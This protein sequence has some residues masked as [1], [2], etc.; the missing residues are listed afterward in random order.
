[1]VS[2]ILPWSKS[3]GRWAILPSWEVCTYFAI[4]KN[5]CERPTASLIWNMAY[6]FSIKHLF[7][8]FAY[9]HS[10]FWSLH[11]NPNN[12]SSSECILIEILCVLFTLTSSKKFKLVELF[13]QSREWSKNIWFCAT[14]ATVHAQRSSLAVARLTLT[15]WRSSLKL[16]FHLPKKLF[17]L[18]Q[19]K[20]FKNE[21]NYFLF[22][23]KS[24][25]SSQY[26]LVM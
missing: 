22:H 14:T 13:F 3:H 8:L 1:M 21:E 15:K 7:L 9:F 5:I 11:Q 23:L 26:F 20:P 24:Y 19:W 4:L 25:F 17:Y 18:I 10:K 12:E 16:D 2:W 6:E